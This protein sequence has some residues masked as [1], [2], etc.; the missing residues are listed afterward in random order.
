MR[1]PAVSIIVAVYNTQKYLQRCLNS[2]VFQS[3]QNIEIIVV[4]DGSTDESQNIINSYAE[5]FPQ[6]IVAI[7]KENGGLSSARKAGI[8]AAKG[9]WVM[10]VDSDD[11]IHPCAVELMLRK[12]SEDDSQMVYAPYAN[13]YDRSKEVGASGVVRATSEDGQVMVAD[14]LRDGN[15]SFWG[16]LWQRE[17]MLQNA[18]FY[19]VWH[20]DVAE[21]PALISKLERV[22]YVRTPLYFYY[23]DNSDS[24][25]KTS[26]YNE[27]RLDLFKIDEWCYR[28]LNLEYECEYKIKLAKRIYLNTHFKEVYDKSVEYAKETWEKYELAEIID[29]LSAEEQKNLLRIL[30]LEETVMPEIVYINDFD[31]KAAEHY[32]NDIKKTFF[33][34]KEIIPLSVENCKSEFDGFSELLLQKKQYKELGIYFAC[35]KIYKTGGV[36]ISPRIEITNALDML[37]FNTATFCMESREHMSMDFFGG[38]AGSSV[39]DEIIRCWKW[40]EDRKIVEAVQQAFDMALIG[41][42][43]VHMHNVEQ[44]GIHGEKVYS[45]EWLWYSFAAYGGCLKR[46]GEDEYTVS[47]EYFIQH[48]KDRRRIEKNYKTVRAEKKQLVQERKLLKQEIRELKAERKQDKRKIKLQI[49]EIKALKQKK[50]SLSVKLKYMQNSVSWR[51]TRPIRFL[52]RL[53]KRK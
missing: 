36:Y 21:I 29:K 4:N 38:M 6:L 42:A 8:E 44:T 51:I 11:W 18:H 48:E 37:K 13:V 46:R 39:F 31:G 14:V 24:I 50:K 40:G 3:F 9:E 23:Q 53:L 17:F 7:E 41:Y 20:E 12:Q 47:L 25:T 30:D 32:G 34:V 45:A 35:K 49:N 5:K 43:G 33:K 19:N 15:N 52:L 16:K 26:D 10:F 28:D 1:K 2:L 22:S 27:K